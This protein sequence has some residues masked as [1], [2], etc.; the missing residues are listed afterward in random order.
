MANDEKAH[1]MTPERWAR[2]RAKTNDQVLAE[3]RADPDAG[4]FGGDPPHKG[5]VKANPSVM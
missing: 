4:A 3:A 1:G 5:R 2:L